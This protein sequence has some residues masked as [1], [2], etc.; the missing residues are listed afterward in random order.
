MKNQFLINK[1]PIFQMFN[2]F[3][4][5]FTYSAKIIIFLCWLHP[6][7]PSSKHLPVQKKTTKTLEKV[8]EICSNLTIKTLE[9]HQ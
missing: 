6:N 7:P 3:I 8:C 4:M 1:K 9:Q 2:C 5:L